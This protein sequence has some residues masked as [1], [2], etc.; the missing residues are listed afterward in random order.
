MPRKLFTLFS[1]DLP[2]FRCRFDSDRPL[3]KIKHLQTLLSQRGPDAVIITTSNDRHLEILRECAKRHIHYSV[4]KPMAT[5]AADAREMERLAKE[6]GIK[7]MV[8]YWNA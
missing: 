1:A 3:H 8:N 5:N 7:L 2:R 6:A 4:E